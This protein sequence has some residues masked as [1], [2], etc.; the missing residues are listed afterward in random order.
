M[1]DAEAPSLTLTLKSRNT[2]IPPVM[3][4]GIAVGID[5]QGMLCLHFYADHYAIADEFRMKAGSDGSASVEPLGPPVPVRNV[6]AAVV[7]TRE[8]LV[9]SVRFLSEALSEQEQ[10]E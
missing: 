1:A 8:A 7:M 2:D 5:P 4:H 3:A 9:A 10:K 6:V